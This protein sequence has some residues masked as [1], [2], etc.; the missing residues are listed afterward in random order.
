MKPGVYRVHA[1]RGEA[2]EA[3]MAALV[4][5]GIVKDGRLADMGK[6]QI[7]EGLLRQLILIGRLPDCEVVPGRILAEAVGFL[8]GV[9]GNQVVHIEKLTRERGA[10][11]VRM[12]FEPIEEPPESEQH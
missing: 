5:A 4:D 10:V 8:F 11:M 1:K 3:I 6:E 12:V 7:L 2:D 9:S